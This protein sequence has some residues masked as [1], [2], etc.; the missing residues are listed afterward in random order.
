MARTPQH[1]AVDLPPLPGAAGSAASP[2][3]SPRGDLHWHE[4]RVE[5]LNTRV[6]AATREPMPAVWEAIVKGVQQALREGGQAAQPRVLVRP[7]P[8]TQ[9]QQGS[10]G[11]QAEASQRLGARQ[12]A[13]FLLFGADGAQ[14]Q[15]WSDALA[16]YLA[17]GER[18]FS[19]TAPL[20]L[21]TVHFTPPPLPPVA[22]IALDFYTPLPFKAQ[23]NARRTSITAAQFGAALVTRVE[24][25]WGVKTPTPDTGKLKLLPWAWRHQRLTHRSKSEAGTTQWLDGCVGTLV[26]KDGWQPLWPWIALAQAIGAGGQLSF[27]MGHCR[28][29]VPAPPMLGK[30]WSPEAL[31][32]ALEQ[33]LARHDDALAELSAESQIPFDA[34]G[35]VRQLAQRLQPAPAPLWQPSP[36]AAFRIVKPD[37]SQ[38]Q[39]EKLGLSELVVQYALLDACAPVFERM[40]EPQSYGYRPG[41]SRQQAA[42][43]I[44]AAIAQGYGW[45]LESDVA[46]FFPS[47]SHALLEQRLRAELPQADGPAVDLIMACVRT[48]YELQGSVQPRSRGLAQG[49]PLSPLLANL[50]LDR[51]DERFA[52][53]T[54]ELPPVRLVRYADDFVLLA[55]SEDDARS[56]ETVVNQ[57]LAELGLRT[58]SEKTAIRQVTEGFE[59][60]GMCF[61]S[62]GQAPSQA[63]LHMPENKPLYV[64]EPGAYLGLSGEALEVR[65]RGRLLLT[66][67]TARVSEVVLLAPASLS[68][69]LLARL[70]ERGIC[71]TL[72]HRGGRHMGCVAP[73]SRTFLARSHRQAHSYERMGDDVQLALAREIAAAKVRNQAALL[74]QRFAAGDAELITRLEQLASGIEA[75]PDRGGIRGLEG[76]AA[77]KFFAR[78]AQDIADP[79]FAWSK[80]LKGHEPGEEPDRINAMLNFGY[81]LLYSRIN[82]GLRAQGLNPYLG[83]LHETGDRFETLVADMQELFRPHVDR[84]VVRLVNLKVLRAEHFE[85]HAGRGMRFGREG[86]KLFVQHFESELLRRPK[87]GGMN[88]ADALNAQALSLRGW[89][90]DGQPLALFKLGRD[91]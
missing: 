31:T 63:E 91:G 26:L 48:G 3:P 76:Q 6:H 12:R 54:D 83:F 19:L 49:A 74:S 78:L 32:G 5:L 38:R 8:V 62:Q 53:G 73:D 82:A 50:V 36:H 20:V 55:R 1:Q 56:A 79:A 2:A 7:D 64:T 28:V 58:S 47:V 9:R 71:V 16:A 87:N 39:I 25:L 60:L 22:D 89:L 77:Q 68:S 59:F 27:A 42:Q 44:E 35:F 86:M 43:A 37:S 24:R 29:L 33:V 23:D 18:N 14:A 41:R 46:D 40:F 85:A 90:C 72:G 57:A 11:T 84:L 67:P 70:Q 51:F 4:L 52:P 61:G 21:Q 30:P 15:A 69:L 65:L 66:R 80:R 17:G 75:A 45:V 10:T 88:L 81:F 13:V 34:P